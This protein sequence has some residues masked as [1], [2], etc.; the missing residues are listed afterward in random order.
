MNEINWIGFLF[1]RYFCVISLE[2][3]SKLYAWYWLILPN[4]RYYL[5]LYYKDGHKR[6]GK[7]SKEYFKPDRIKI[8]KINGYKLKI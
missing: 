2:R 4:W 8:W 5:R 7:Y 3:E 6:F 1:A